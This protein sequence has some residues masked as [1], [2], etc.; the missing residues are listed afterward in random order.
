MNEQTKIDTTRNA[1]NFFPLAIKP[2]IAKQRE[3]SLNLT[4]LF[5]VY[6][7]IFNGNLRAKNEFSAR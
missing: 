5:Q 3:K 1:N 7:L 4:I 2:T 6:L